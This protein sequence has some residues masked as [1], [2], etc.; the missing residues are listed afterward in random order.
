[1]KSIRSASRLL[2]ATAAV[3][4]M[5]TA[6]IVSQGPPTAAEAQGQKPRPADRSGRNRRPRRRATLM[7]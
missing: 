2:T 7:E 1:M 4:L 3:I 6:V 5:I